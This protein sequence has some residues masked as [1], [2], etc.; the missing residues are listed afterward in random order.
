[1]TATVAT[2]TEWHKTQERTAML[3]NWIFEENLKPTLELLAQY[4][5]YDFS[6]DDWNAVRFG[7]TETDEEQDRWC[8]Y[9]FSV[10]ER[11][12]FRVAQ[13]SGSRVIFFQVESKP[14]IEG[15]VETV[16][17]IAQHYRITD[18]T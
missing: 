11:V 9:E 7:V 8:E 10:P 3:R 14:E 12:A 5:G 15:K 16:L 18:F 6:P 2:V 1:V 17:R 13:S 4:A